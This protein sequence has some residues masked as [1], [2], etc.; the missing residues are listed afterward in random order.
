[1][2]ENVYVTKKKR[3]VFDLYIFLILIF[4]TNFILNYF[5]IEN[6]LKTK[7]SLGFIN[8]S[9]KLIF[10][11][12]AIAIILT[13]YDLFFF[14]KI[15]DIIFKLIQFKLKTQY[16]IIKKAKAQTK[17]LHN[18]NYKITFRFKKYFLIFEKKLATLW[19]SMTN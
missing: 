3:I 19:I 1:M 6:I 15:I 8:S 18:S 11:R 16:W 7:V 2:V 13:I 9:Y 14:F 4:L 5:M 17:K 12:N 10:Y